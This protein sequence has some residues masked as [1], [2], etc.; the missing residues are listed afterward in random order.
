MG[1]TLYERTNYLNRDIEYL[2][3]CTIREYDLK[4]AGFSLI[5]Q[6]HMLPDK[7][8]Q[9]LAK[10]DK[11]PR[12]IEIGMLQKDKGF[13]KALL[14]AFVE[15]RKMFFEANSLEDK[16]ILTLKK[17]AIFVIDKTCHDNIFGE[18]EFRVKNRYLGYMYLNKKE[19]YYTN[20]ST[21]IDMK[22]LG[23]DVLTYHGDYMLDF[24]RDVFTMAIYSSREEI[25]KYITDFISDYRNNRLA[26]GYYRNLDAGMF[27]TVIDPE[28]G[29]MNIR[30]IDDNEDITLDI[31]YNYFNYIVPIVN[32]FV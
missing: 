15:A 14:E 16:D 32:I 4:S 19:L 21:P 20:S 6:F 17:D 9:Y 7:T 30:D 3:N 28:V 1:S 18:L 25:I 23:E 29:R 31:T 24:I 2:L 10:I 26:Y 22:G 11:E 8:I 13:A 12:N 27:Y 5:K